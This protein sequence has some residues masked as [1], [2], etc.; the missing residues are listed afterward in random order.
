M[1]LWQIKAA[2]YTAV[3]GPDVLLALPRKMARAPRTVVAAKST[4]GDIDT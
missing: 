3:A 2:A 4:L 1:A